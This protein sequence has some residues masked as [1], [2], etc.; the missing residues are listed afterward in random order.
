MRGDQ[1]LET[2]LALPADKQ[3]LLK[4]FKPPAHTPHRNNHEEHVFHFR[5]QVPIQPFTK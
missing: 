5:N 2:F 4:T 1:K 3:F